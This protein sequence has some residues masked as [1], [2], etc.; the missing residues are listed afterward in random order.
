MEQYMEQE[1]VGKS[2]AA[3]RLLRS[4]LEQELEDDQSDEESVATGDILFFFA[5]VGVFA[6]L[7]GE[8]HVVVYPATLA[9]LGAALYLRFSR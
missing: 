3:R 9:F 7:A 2:V 4:A 1:D 6:I 8:P 5:G